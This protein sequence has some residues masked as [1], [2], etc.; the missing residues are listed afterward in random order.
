MNTSN[1]K[2]QYQE[3]LNQLLQ[4]LQDV[5]L[6]GNESAQA[7]ELD[8]TRVGRLSRMD[9]MQAQAMSIESNRRRLQQI[10]N[11]HAA[12]KRL[13]SDEYGWCLECGEEINPKRLEFN[14]A[15]ELCIDCA[16][17]VDIQS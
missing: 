10:K 11:I 12:L 8:Q 2:Q 15:V 5:E 1:K 6:T 7:V 9:A 16:N 3:K 4:E 17:K 14:P 13:E